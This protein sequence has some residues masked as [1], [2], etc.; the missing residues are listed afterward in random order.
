M[1]LKVT[2][3]ST[4]KLARERGVSCVLM[5]QQGKWLVEWRLKHMWCFSTFKIKLSKLNLSKFKVSFIFE[6]KIQSYREMVDFLV[7]FIWYRMRERERERKKEIKDT[8][9]KRIPQ[10]ELPVSVTAATFH[11]FYWDLGQE[12]MSTERCL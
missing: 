11:C 10:Q 12:A 9:L 1:L 7:A 4:E 3:D 6:S 8:L 2:E 5:N